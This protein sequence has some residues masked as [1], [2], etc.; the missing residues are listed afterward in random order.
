MNPIGLESGLGSSAFPAAS[1]SRADF[2]AA[3]ERA[4]L[5]QAESSAS[6]AAD[7]QS[8]ARKAAEEF[9]GLTLILPLLKQMRDSATA[10]PPWG[11][12][13]AEK[14]MQAMADVHTAQA[15]ARASNLP[16]VDRLSRDLMARASPPA[17]L[18]PIRGFTSLESSRPRITVLPARAA[19]PLSGPVPLAETTR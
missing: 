16:I 3:F 7:T 17:A 15:I 13:Q 10:P 2:N 1:S 8:Q 14:Q 9:V 18:D 19:Q 4:R 5:D 6:G 11:P 12:S